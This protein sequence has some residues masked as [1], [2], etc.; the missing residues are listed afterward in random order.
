MSNNNNLADKV[1]D[2]GVLILSKRD[3]IEFDY[4][5]K[6]KGSAA[7]KY[8]AKSIKGNRFAYVSNLAKI[9]QVDIPK[10]LPDPSKV[11]P[12]EQGLAMLKHVMRMRQPP[13]RK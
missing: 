6:I 1:N 7:I 2:H 5:L 3:A 13:P 11:I 9:L 10:D 4:L 12:I 8:A